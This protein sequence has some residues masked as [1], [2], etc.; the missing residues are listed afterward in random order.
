MVEGAFNVET[1][2]FSVARV[3]ARAL[4]GLSG[5]CEFEIVGRHDGRASTPRN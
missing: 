3:A 2:C 1:W 5:A 4:I